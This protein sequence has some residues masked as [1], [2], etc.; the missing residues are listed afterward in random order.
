MQLTRDDVGRIAALGFAESYFVVAGDGWLRLRNR[1]GR[2]VFSDGARCLI[3]DDR[4]EGCAVYPTICRGGRAALDDDCPHAREFPSAPDGEP[5]VL[6][7]AS[8]LKAER[9]ARMK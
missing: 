5:K 4:P 6:E 9:K 8:R 7:I 1:S 2:C 3:Y